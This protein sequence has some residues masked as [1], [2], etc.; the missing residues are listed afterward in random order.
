M[1]FLGYS[2]LPMLILAVIGIFT[3]LS[4]E[5]GMIASLLLASWSSYSCSGLIAVLLNRLD[6]KMLILYPLFLFYISFAMII[7]Y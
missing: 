1:S 4:G 3:N 7:I 6:S 2:L 5:F